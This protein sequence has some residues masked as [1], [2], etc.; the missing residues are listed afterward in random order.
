M[1]N[2]GQFPLFMHDTWRVSR[3]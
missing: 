1:I 3:C 2:S